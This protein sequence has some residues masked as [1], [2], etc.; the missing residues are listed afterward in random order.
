MQFEEFLKRVSKINNLDL[1]G[2]EAHFLMAPQ[3]SIQQLSELAIEE[4]K[5]RNAG[6]LAVFY[7]NE[8]GETTLVLILR[9]TY[10][11]VH[12]IGRAHV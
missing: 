5:P 11:G 9:K 2:Q 3:E 7:P 1:P 8:E 4:R 6:V 10:K 12:K